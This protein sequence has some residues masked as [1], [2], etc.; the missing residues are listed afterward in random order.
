MD[1]QPEVKIESVSSTACEMLATRGDKRLMTLDMFYL[2][3][4]ALSYHRSRK[5]CL[6][7]VQTFCRSFFLRLWLPLRP[8]SRRTIIIDYTC[9]KTLINYFSSRGQRKNA[10]FRCSTFFVTLNRFRS[11]QFPEPFSNRHEVIISGKWIY[12]DSLF[13]PNF[14][15]EQYVIVFVGRNK[16]GV[17]SMLR[18]DVLTA[19][20]A[21][22][23]SGW[24]STETI[25]VDDLWEI[26]APFRYL[27]AI[28]P[29][30]FVY[31]MIRVSNHHRLS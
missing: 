2:D 5:R 15:P 28:K 26:I 10:R 14:F 8:G 12:R 20:N 25:R 29:K 11:K 4:I 21:E 7:I 3:L 27:N 16:F 31:T 23:L 17:N 13:P 24:T 18:L 22:R 30:C 1:D 9:C 6:I 19:E